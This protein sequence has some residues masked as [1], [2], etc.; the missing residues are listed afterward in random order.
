MEITSNTMVREL[1]GETQTLAA[2]DRTRP[3]V[4]RCEEVVLD[5][6]SAMGEARPAAWC[7][8]DSRCSIAGGGIKR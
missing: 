8:C 5:E 1:H 4:R 6:G 7:D 2:R 3:A